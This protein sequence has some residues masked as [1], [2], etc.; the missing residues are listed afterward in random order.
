MASIINN[1][2]VCDNVEELPAT[3]EGVAIVKGSPNGFY[4]RGEGGAWVREEFFHDNESWP[5]GSL[6]TA[7]GEIDPSTVLNV[8]K[9]ECVKKEEIGTEVYYSWVRRE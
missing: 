5:V 2:F 6:Y 4:S 3:F 8:G 7:L 9:W 1:L